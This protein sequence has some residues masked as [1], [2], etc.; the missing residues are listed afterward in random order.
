MLQGLIGETLFSV[1]K[2]GEKKREKESEMLHCVVDFLPG[3]II[4]K[5]DILEQ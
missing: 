5:L 1:L 3:D 4:P 2:V